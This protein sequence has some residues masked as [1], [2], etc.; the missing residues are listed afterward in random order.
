MVED[1]SFHILA[2]QE[3]SGF[4]CRAPVL[5]KLL[6]YWDAKRAGRPWPLRSEIDPAEIKTLLPN[7]M[8]VDITQAPFRVRY[9]LVGTEI[10]RFAHFDFTGHFLDELTFDSGEAMD[11][12]DCYRQVCTTGRPGFGMVHWR[13][14]EANFRW[15]EFLICPLSTN[16]IDITQ[17]ISAEDYEPLNPVEFDSIAHT[18]PNR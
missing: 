13:T 11:W 16:G 15:I 1:D 8:L 18:A 4:K 6:A 9:R 10:V 3:I 2:A 14:L 12:V 7:I 5:E 17:C